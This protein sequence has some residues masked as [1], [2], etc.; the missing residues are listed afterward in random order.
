MV[1]DNLTP[2]KATGVREA[3]ESAGAELR[4]LPPYSPDLNPIENMWGKVKGALRPLAARRIP[5][6][7]DRGAL[8]TVTPSDC[9][10]YFRH[11]G[12]LATSKGAPL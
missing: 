10:G 2:H 8:A 4:Y 6:R 1:M 3:I 7:R 9:V 11:C 5:T 12:Y